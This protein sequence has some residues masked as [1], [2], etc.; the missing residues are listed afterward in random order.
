MSLTFYENIIWIDIDILLKMF[1][2]EYVKW[3]FI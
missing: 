3:V 1:M 2:E